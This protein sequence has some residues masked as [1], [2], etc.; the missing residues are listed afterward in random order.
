MSFIDEIKSFFDSHAAEIERV[1]AVA[2]AVDA[3]P[4]M[5]AAQAAAGLPAGARQAIADALTRLNDE[6]AAAVQQ[7]TENG[8]KAG[9]AAAAA[10]L[11]P[12]ADAPAEV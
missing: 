4:L 8:R 10:E 5:Q 3:D 12:P 1:T 2:A 7:A 6:F 9:H 11:A